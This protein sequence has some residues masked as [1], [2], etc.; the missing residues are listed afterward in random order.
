ML[1][2]GTTNLVRIALAVAAEVLRTRVPAS[3]CVHASQTLL[4]P[5]GANTALSLG[6]PGREKTH[7]TARWTDYALLG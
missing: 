7:S 3:G 5:Q 2:G 6:R 1:P 4:F